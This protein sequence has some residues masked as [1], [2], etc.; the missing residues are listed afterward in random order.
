MQDFFHQHYGRFV[1]E[2]HHIS[3]T[4]MQ[5]WEK[6]KVF[7]SN[8]YLLVTGVLL[9]DIPDIPDAIQPTNV[10]L[11]HCLR[12]NSR[13]WNRKVSFPKDGDDEGDFAAYRSR[14]IGWT[15][16]SYGKRFGNPWVAPTSLGGGRFRRAAR[17]VM[18][19]SERPGTLWYDKQGSNMI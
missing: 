9:I 11:C 14:V 15:N 12:W 10:C 4:W 5:P 17:K 3:P 2:F 1:S 18:R 19:A 16:S 8:T 6:G 13:E 7:Y